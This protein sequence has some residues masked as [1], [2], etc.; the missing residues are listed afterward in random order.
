M[1]SALRKE[2]EREERKGTGGGGGG[3]FARRPH[4]P[5]LGSSSLSL[6][7]P[8]RLFDFLCRRREGVEGVRDEM[9]AAGADSWAREI[10]AAE[11]GGRGGRR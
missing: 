11:T 10:V 3:P 4:S 8:G 5:A 6:N 1:R 9:G 7:P 2:G